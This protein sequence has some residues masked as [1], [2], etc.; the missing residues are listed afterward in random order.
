[1]PLF[2]IG[3]VCDYI[4]LTLSPLPE[5]VGARAGLLEE[6]ELKVMKTSRGQWVPY[7]VMLSKT[8]I[9]FCEPNTKQL[10]GTMNISLES[11]FI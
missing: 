1:M 4:L 11:K 6:G 5:K 2:F 9:K 7:H 8:D 10:D 3:I